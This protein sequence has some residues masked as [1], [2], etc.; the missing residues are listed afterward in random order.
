MA[1]A[2]PHWRQAALPPRLPPEDVER[3]RAV[4]HDGPA[5]SRRHRAL[6]LLLA[7]LGLRAQDVLSL[8]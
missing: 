6:L 7:R 1:W 4:D 3:V 8:C 2:P 5:S